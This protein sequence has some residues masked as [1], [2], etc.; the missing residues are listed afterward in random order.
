MEWGLGEHSARV[1]PVFVQLITEQPGD[2]PLGTESPAYRTNAST[3][4]T[5]LLP[6]SNVAPQLRASIVTVAPVL[7][8]VESDWKDWA[9]WFIWASRLST[10]PR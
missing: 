9:G 1:G 6:K 7:S 2:G 3:Q 4:T 5:G 10:I 8:D